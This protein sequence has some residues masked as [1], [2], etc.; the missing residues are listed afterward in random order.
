MN[1]K[2]KISIPE[3][4]HEN[5]KEMS[6]AE[7]GKFCSVCQQN[8]ID[9][10][11]S[12]DKEII[13]AYNKNSCGRFRLSQ[14]ERGYIFPKE[15]K[16]IW[17]I[18]AA[19]FI[20]LLGLGNHTARAQGRPR[21]EQT[22]NQQDS[23]NPIVEYIGTIY[24]T[25]TNMPVPGVEVNVKG[26]RTFVT[27]DFNGEFTIKGKKR[28]VLICKSIG[29]ETREFRLRKKHKIIIKLTHV[30]TP[31]VIIISKIKSENED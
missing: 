3:P 13:A 8:V 26:T 19:T 27:T 16:S 4:C 6:H 5:W 2:I 31:G 1:H 21:I 14:V 12:S 10:T 30:P 15:K 17:V 23:K 20:A 7:K 9:F 11:K 29:Y 25:E 28:D 24:D 18:A 22:T